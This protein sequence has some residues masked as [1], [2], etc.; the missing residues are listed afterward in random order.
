MQL[1]LFVQG[2]QDGISSVFLFILF[3]LLLLIMAVFIQVGLH[4]R[5]KKKGVQK[6]GKCLLVI[7]IQYCICSEIE[8][9][10][11]QVEWI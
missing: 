6:A 8:W 5:I 1:F 4:I 3:I 7:F 10:L 9:L 11:L 2:L